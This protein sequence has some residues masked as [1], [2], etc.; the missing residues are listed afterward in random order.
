MPPVIQ[1]YM[2]SLFL[3]SARSVATARQFLFLLRQCSSERHFTPAYMLCRKYINILSYHIT[4]IYFL[5][6]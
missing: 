5:R 3:A 6:V 1:A 4:H 2:P